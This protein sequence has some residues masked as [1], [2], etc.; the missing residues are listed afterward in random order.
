ML[1]IF[2]MMDWGSNMWIFMGIGMA[3][4]VLIV[5]IIIFYYLFAHRSRTNKVYVTSQIKNQESVKKKVDVEVKHDESHFCP[6]CGEKIEEKTVI[7]PTCGSE[8]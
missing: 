2:Q 6:N 1:N 8:I 5:I 7:C 4:F 3:I